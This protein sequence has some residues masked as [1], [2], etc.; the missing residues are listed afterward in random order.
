[1]KSAS[2]KRRDR[3]RRGGKTTKLATQQLKADAMVQKQQEK[4]AAK[5][6][7]AETRARKRASRKENQETSADLSAPAIGTFQRLHRHQHALQQQASLLNRH[8]E[9]YLK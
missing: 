9:A 3:G 5:Q 8:T 6:A 7:R 1:M 2:E 4:E